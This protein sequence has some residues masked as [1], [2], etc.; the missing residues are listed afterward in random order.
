MSEADDFNLFDQSTMKAINKVLNRVMKVKPLDSAFFPFNFCQTIET[1]GQI[2][3]S[4]SKITGLININPGYLNVCEYKLIGRNKFYAK[5]NWFELESLTLEPDGNSLTFQFKD[6]TITLKPKVDKKNNSVAPKL[7]S[8]LHNYFNTIFIQLP[9]L[10]EKGKE[11]PKR[12]D[13]SVMRRPDLALKILLDSDAPPEEAFFNLFFVFPSQ[14]DFNI[15]NLFSQFNEKIIKV[16]P[17]MKSINKICLPTTATLALHLNAIKQYLNNTPRIHTLVFRELTHQLL[18]G[19]EKDFPE[20]ITT[21]VFDSFKIETPILQAMSSIVRPGNSNNITTI[22]FIKTTFE[23]TLFTNF[24]ESSS[25]SEA[26]AN[27]TSLT[28]TVS[29]PISV[30]Y[31]ENHLPNLKSITIICSGTNHKIICEDL[32]IENDKLEKIKYSNCKTL[33]FESFEI[34]RKI[35]KFG[36]THSNWN[37]DSL[38]VVFKKCL[39]YRYSDLELNFSYAKMTN[40]EWNEFYEKLSKIENDNGYITSIKWNG[41]PISENFWRLCYKCGRLKQLIAKDYKSVSDAAPRLP[42]P[43]RFIKGSPSIEKLII[44][45]TKYVLQDIIDISL[46]I[47]QKGSDRNANRLTHVDFSGCNKEDAYSTINHVLRNS[48]FITDCSFQAKNIND[49][50]FNGFINKVSNKNTYLN[51]EWPSHAFATIDKSFKLKPEDFAQM[52]AK[53]ETLRTKPQDKTPKGT[54]I[55]PPKYNT[56]GKKEE[57]VYLTHFPTSYDDVQIKADADSDIMKMINSTNSS[58]YNRFLL[59]LQNSGIL[60]LPSPPEKDDQSYIPESMKESWRDRLSLAPDESSQ[61]YAPPL[62]DMDCMEEFFNITYKS[63]IVS[64]R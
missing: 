26:L 38:F 50:L 6:A 37:P 47:L 40:D 30:S 11:L 12:I 61:V 1:I 63:R 29:Q 27:I 24:L 25:N 64:F 14:F 55:P 8:I 15:F 44:P 5:K 39:E 56:L 49:E 17:L 20:N 36:I 28:L 18:G 34:N 13:N 60:T 59:G 7:F 57:T 43:L 53:C 2:K 22:K 21:I 32:A 52:Y 45:N 42:L 62:P 51:I 16:L 31:I 41:N 46:A 9:K 4:K 35:S 3:G 58:I 10:V 33:D 54:P 23:Q 19:F 48:P